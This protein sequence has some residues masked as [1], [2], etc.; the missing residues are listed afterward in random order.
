MKS[1]EEKKKQEPFPYQFII[2]KSIYI[3]K[4]FWKPNF[5]WANWAGRTF[6][7]SE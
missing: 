2:T 6:E 4:P 5:I 7:A 1:N 3:E